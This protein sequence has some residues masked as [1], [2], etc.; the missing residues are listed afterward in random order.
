VPGEHIGGPFA[1]FNG[2]AVNDP[3]A[4]EVLGITKGSKHKKQENYGRR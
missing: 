1:Q 3:G 4:F 2:I